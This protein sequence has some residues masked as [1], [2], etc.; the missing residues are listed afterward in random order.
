[1]AQ[2]AFV[3][4]ATGFIGRLLVDELRRT[5]WSV[6][7]LAR[8]SSDVQGLRESGIELV[9]GDI[10]SGSLDDDALEG[11]STVFHLAAL[12]F[13]RSD[14]EYEE[15]NAEGTRRVLKAV[16]DRGSSAPRFVYLSSYAAA[17]PAADGRPRALDAVPLP[18]TSYGRTKLEG[19]LA[20]LA[21]GRR[22]IDAIAIRAPVVYGPG[23][24]ALLPYFKLVR[25]GIAPMPGGKD[26][27]LHLIFAP[28]LVHALVR[29]ADAPT[30][31][32][33]VAEPFAHTWEDVVTAIAGAMG[34]RPVHLPLPAAGVRMAA[35][36]TQAAG[37]MIGKA[38][39]FNRE[40]AA[41]MLAS[42]WVHEL[43]GS[44]HLLPPE[45]V[46]PL[47][48]GIQRTVRWYIRQGWL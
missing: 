1:M 11:V 9:I 22:G 44:E 47:H 8:K 30:G 19:E 14:R 29:A 23:D 41:E 16:Q 46:T 45:R 32:Y 25:H 42:A 38:V 35:A 15:A 28:D 13:A 17:G 36:L 3:T 39:A 18:L 20:T 2:R 24:R 26:R 48:E 40:K 33:A 37:R 10:T 12:T 5:G 27:K 4:G 7:A 31:L 21:A 6:R 43:V 34:K